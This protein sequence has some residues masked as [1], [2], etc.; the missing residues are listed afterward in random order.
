MISATS[1]V[2][3]KGYLSHKIKVFQTLLFLDLVRRVLIS[4]E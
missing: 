4:L 2:V 3:E 1:K